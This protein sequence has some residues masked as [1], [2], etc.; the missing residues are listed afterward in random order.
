M[1]LDGEEPGESS[2]SFPLG[3]LAPSSLSEAP[4]KPSL[5]R[6]FLIGPHSEV[7][8]SEQFSSTHTLK[9]ISGDCLISQLP[10]KGVLFGRNTKLTKN[11]SFL[12]KNP[13]DEISIEAMR[14]TQHI[15]GNSR[16]QHAYTK[17][18]AFKTS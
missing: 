9:I 13:R 8:G 5:P 18:Y 10:E 3:E 1:R 7:T 16:S 15:P 6:L 11:K 2:Q 4:W 12:L 14:K 17:L